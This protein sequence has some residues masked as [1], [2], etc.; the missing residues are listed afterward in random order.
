MKRRVAQFLSSDDCPVCKGTAQAREAFRQVRRVGHHGDIAHSPEKARGR[1]AAQ[2]LR[3]QI[4]LS[5]ADDYPEKVLVA[6]RVSKILPDVSMF[7]S[8]SSRAR[9]LLGAGA[10]LY[11]MFNRL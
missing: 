8:I 4:E 6:Q 1:D 2:T 10:P 9:L 7:C 5:D 3:R 11:Q